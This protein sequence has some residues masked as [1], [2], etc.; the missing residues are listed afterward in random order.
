MT[1][2]RPFGRAA[3]AALAVLLLA[4]PSMAAQ[5]AATDTLVV[6]PHRAAPG[7]DQRPLRARQN[8]RRLGKG[9]GIG[10][11]TGQAGGAVGHRQMPGR[12]QHDV[13]RQF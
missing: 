11:R 12:G 13:D 4:L 1:K 7:E 10:G 6:R 2:I 3:L 5:T 8:G 9:G